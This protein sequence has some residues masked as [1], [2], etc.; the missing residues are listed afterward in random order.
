MAPRFSGPPKRPRTGAPSR[1]RSKATSILVSRQHWRHERPTSARSP[2]GPDAR[3]S[4]WRPAPE[5]SA[6][7]VD[8]DRGAD[9]LRP[10]LLRLDHAHQPHR[11]T[12]ADHYPVHHLRGPGA[13]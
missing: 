13:P 6:G 4:A 1:K 10:L 7:L 8:L 11:A 5:L 2:R 9:Y 12:A 3:P